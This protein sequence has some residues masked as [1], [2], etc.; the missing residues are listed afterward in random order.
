MWSTSNLSHCTVHG[1]LELNEQ[2]NNENNAIRYW[3]QLLKIEGKWWS[4]IKDQDQRQRLVTQVRR[5]QTELARLSMESLSISFYVYILYIVNWY[6][7]YTIIIL[8]RVRN[9]GQSLSIEDTLR[10]L[11]I[12][13]CTNCACCRDANILIGIPRSIQQLGPYLISIFLVGDGVGLL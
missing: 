8:Q 6:T 3:T 12:Y 11:D 10:F 5:T 2:T 1:K 4:K 7:I 13:E 9:N